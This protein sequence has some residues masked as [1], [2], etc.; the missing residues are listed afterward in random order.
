MKQTLGRCGFLLGRA[1][2]VLFFALAWS[3]LA[4][5]E[6]LKDN[7][8]ESLETT[9]ESENHEESLETTAESENYKRDFC[10]NLYVDRYCYQNAR[11]RDV[12]DQCILSSRQNIQELKV[13]YA[14]SYFF[15]KDKNSAG[16]YIKL[17]AAE[18]RG[19]RCM[20]QDSLSNFAHYQS[21]TNQLMTEHIEI[22]GCT[23]EPDLLSS[24]QTVSPID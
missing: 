16:I 20:S 18:S 24:L 1:I 17:K 19:V 21:C 2:L 8:E 11:D 10:N 9:A 12:F 5:V 7:H 23:L 14:G 22:M 15:R 4:Q 13:K 3:S 6:D